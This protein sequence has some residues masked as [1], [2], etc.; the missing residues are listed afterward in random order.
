[1]C[2]AQFNWV[3]RL[4][5]I[6]ETHFLNNS[7]QQS[8]ASH[9]LIPYSVNLSVLKVEP[10]INVFASIWALDNIGFMVAASLVVLGRERFK[11]TIPGS[12]WQRRG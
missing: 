4:N 1:M 11:D 10:A 12:L 5:H 3:S 8:T 6:S 9:L 2:Q 7:F